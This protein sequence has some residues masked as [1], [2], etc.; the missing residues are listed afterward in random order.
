M[1]FPSFED[2]FRVARDEAL[3]RNTKLSRDAVEREGSDANILIAA[4]AAAA[5]ECIAQLTRVAAGLYLDSARGSLLDLLVFDRYGLVRKPA[6]AALGQVSFVSTLQGST[7]TSFVIAQGT[8][9]QTSDGIQFEAVADTTFPARNAGPIV[10]T[11]RS[12]LAGANQQARLGTITRIVDTITG[13]PADLQ[14]INA[15]ATSGSD[16]EETDESLRA[17]ARA[18]WTTARAGTLRAIETA[19]LGVPGVRSATAFEA[20]DSIGR[21]ER[22]VGL[23]VTDAFTE[24]L[25]FGATTGTSLTVFQSQALADTVFNAL[26][27]VRPAGVFVQV[28]VASVLLQSI[29]LALTFQAGADASGTGTSSRLAVGSITAQARAAVVNTINALRPGQKLERQNLVNALR[30]ISGLLVTGNEILTPSV[31]LTINPL[32]ILRTTLGLV[33]VV[34]ATYNQPSI[35]LQT[36]IVNPGFVLSTSQ[37]VAL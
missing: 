9:L 12:L 21:A 31:D 1:D 24:S 10:V 29:Q 3:I 26:A 34:N 35:A 5:D 36:G 37:G 27:D 18:F 7:S 20:I 2:L 25:A 14:V 22:Y 33:S 11:V 19:A 4:A 8:I 17:R 28:I 32:Q 16:D 30:S 6:A 13:A 15:S 23:V